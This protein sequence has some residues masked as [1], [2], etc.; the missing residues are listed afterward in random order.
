MS[1]ESKHS[2]TEGQAR[3]LAFLVFWVSRAQVRYDTSSPSSCPRRWSMRAFFRP[4]VY[5]GQG[6]GR[7]HLGAPGVIEPAK[8]RARHFARS[9]HGRRPHAEHRCCSG[10]ELLKANLGRPNE[11]EPLTVSTKMATLIG[12]DGCRFP[13]NRIARQWWK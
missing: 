11:L 10:S 1:P 12:E 3:A 9:A 13:L 8:S 6:T 5:S 7:Q 2:L 4:A